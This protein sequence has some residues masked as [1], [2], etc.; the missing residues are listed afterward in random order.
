[1]RVS[2]ET[3]FL[4]SGRMFIVEQ[5]ILIFILQL[6]NSVVLASGIHQSDS[7]TH[8]HVSVLFQSQNTYVTSYLENF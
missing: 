3:P 2:F 4:E 5:F 8:I 7:V 6:I 1:M